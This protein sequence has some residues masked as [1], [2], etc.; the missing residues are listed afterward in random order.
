[1]RFIVDL[2]HRWGIYLTVYTNDWSD[3]FNYIACNELC[4]AMLVTHN[5]SQEP[6]KSC[7]SQGDIRGNMLV[8]PEWKFNGKKAF[9]CY[10]QET[11]N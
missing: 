11:K 10:C 8:I 1:M 9:Y 5:D 3:E 4:T 7:D 6:I 2:V